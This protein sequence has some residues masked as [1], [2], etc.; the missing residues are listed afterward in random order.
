MAQRL[1]TPADLVGVTGLEIV[2]ATKSVTTSD[3]TLAAGTPVTGITA[4]RPAG[5]TATS[6]VS[7][8]DD[9]RPVISAVNGKQSIFFDT[10]TRQ[11]DIPTKTNLPNGAGDKFWF[12]VVKVAETRTD[13]R[14]T[15]GYGGSNQTAVAYKLR[16]GG[17]P[18]AD[19]GSTGYAV[20]SVA[21]ASTGIS[22]IAEQYT[23]SDTTSRARYNGNSTWSTYV[24]PRST[25]LS[26]TAHFGNWPLYGNGSSHHL[27]R[28]IWGYGTP[29]AADWQRL[30]G[31]ASWDSGDN[32][33]SLVDGH[34]YKT[35]APTIDD[36]TGGATGATGTAATTL[37]AVTAASTALLA[38]AGAAAVTLSPIGSTSA[39]SAA[40]TAQAAST[41]DGI[42]AAGAGGL[43]V[44]GSGAAALGPV[45]GAAAGALPITG[46]AATQIGS[47]TAAA[48]GT[49]PVSGAASATLRQITTIAAAR[50]DISGTA[51]TTLGPV[52]AHG[53]GGTGQLTTGQGAIV[54]APVTAAAAG[55]LPISATAAAPLGAITAAGAGQL[56][57][58]GQA[59]G[60]LGAVTAAAVGSAPRAAGAAVQLEPISAIAAGVL[61]ITGIG[62]ATLGSIAITA[63][64]IGDPDRPV[65]PAIILPQHR[66]VVPARQRSFTVPRRPRAFIIRKGTCM[67]SITKYPAEERQYQADWTADLAGQTITGEPAASSSD[68]TL[69]VDGVDM[70]GAVMKFW[71]RGGTS[72]RAAT[73]TF[74]APTSGGED[75]VFQQTVIVY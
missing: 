63:T 41:L 8:R 68:P 31:W 47:V 51:S 15:W 23:T 37:A 71:L 26:N 21:V 56:A 61:P 4:Q 50:A 7:F 2:D 34:A 54:L 9:Y 62:A 40:I 44:S 1:W 42:S 28:R 72:G 19:V 66:F 55:A 39:S 13:D 33:A 43:A 70:A 48:S 25:S 45:T 69:I 59:A 6:I 36:G 16:Q 65:G 20:G 17:I 38:I 60:T 27:L 35:A 74:V 67:S 52:I 5:G 10:S 53:T 18:Y 3:G 12:E 14:Y 11:L 30:E 32:G 73:I 64:A 57:A 22:I 29:S 46:T 75:L 58:R 49:L 24:K